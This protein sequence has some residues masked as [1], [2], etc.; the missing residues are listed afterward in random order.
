MEPKILTVAE[1]NAVLDRIVK[2]ALDR[3]SNRIGVI[4]TLKNEIE[5]A[6][7]VVDTGASE[8]N[9]D[10][11]HLDRLI[12]RQRRLEAEVREEIEAVHSVGG[13]I[14]DPRSGL[15]DFFSIVDGKL[16]FLCWKRGE[17][18]IRYWHTVEEGYRGRRPLRARLPREES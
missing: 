11:Q 9:P 15:V 18:Q 8:T 7:L 10:R 5:V 12:D 4:D 14:K 6:R 1:A 16:A 3:L 13:V 17:D 2:P